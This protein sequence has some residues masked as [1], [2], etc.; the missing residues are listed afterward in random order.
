MVACNATI[1]LYCQK[2]P[3]PRKGCGLA[4]EYNANASHCNNFCRQVVLERGLRN[5]D[6]KE[7]MFKI[8]ALNFQNALILK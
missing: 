1:G 2:I 8:I 5:I 7:F 4:F 3:S 6:I